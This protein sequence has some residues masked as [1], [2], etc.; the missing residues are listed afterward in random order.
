MALAALSVLLGL[1]LIWQ[2]RHRK[3]IA[4]VGGFAYSAWLVVL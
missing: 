2:G 1:L 4:V 3:A